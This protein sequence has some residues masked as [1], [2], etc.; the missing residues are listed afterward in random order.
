M[1]KSDDNVLVVILA[2]FVVV[3]IWLSRGLIFF[4]S[5]LA[6]GS[7]VWGVVGGFG[8]SLPWLPTVGATFLG[9]VVLRC[10]ALVVRGK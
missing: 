8:Y 6:I 1:A 3:G 4:V 2:V 9:I 5:A 7:L 10:L